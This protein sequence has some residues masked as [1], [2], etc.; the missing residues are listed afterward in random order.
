MKVSIRNMKDYANPKVVDMDG[1]V[2]FIFEVAGVKLVV[3]T[4][5]D[6]M[7]IRAPDSN[8]AVEPISSNMV[9]IRPVDYLSDD[10]WK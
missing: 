10:G 2:E 9:L 3:R 5:D 4:N 8:I 1:V 7:N 6:V